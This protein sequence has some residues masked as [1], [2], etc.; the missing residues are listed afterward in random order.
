MAACGVTAAENCEEKKTDQQKRLFNYK[1][2]G[3]RSPEYVGLPEEGKPSLDPEYIPMMRTMM[4]KMMTPLSEIPF[5]SDAIKKTVTTK[6]VIKKGANN[7]EEV[8]VLIHRPKALKG[9]C[10]AAVI[11]AHGGGFVA[12]DAEIFTPVY[13]LHSVHYG[14]VGFNVD[15]GV[16]PEH[17]NEGWREVYATLKYVYENAEELGVDKTK[18]ALEGTSSGM[19]HIFNVCYQ[20]AKN[21][22]T[23]MCRMVLSEI[24]MLTSVLKFTPMKDLQLK[25]ERNMKES[26]DVIYQYM[27]GDNYKDHVEEKD[28]MLFPDLVADKYLKNY[29]PVVFFSAE[30][31]MFNGANKQFAE[32]LEKHGKLLEF[33]LIR[34]LGHH[35]TASKNN[36]VHMAFGDRL[37]CINIYLKQ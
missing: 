11:F 21:G 28:P 17:R 9:K 33:R 19:H 31:C 25:E 6:L 16:A 5:F 23:G 29:P 15:Y 12:G 2:F 27:L 36:E 13:C 22:E 24:G 26:L 34:G 10:N 35:F 3:K 18:I 37:K 20:M 8:N 32:R 4:K 7:D 14:V 30:F 1:P